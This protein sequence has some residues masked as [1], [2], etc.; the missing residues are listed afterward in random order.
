M[1]R[2]KANEANLEKR[3][4][5]W[6]F[7]GLV[8]ILAVTLSCVAWTSYDIRDIKNASLDLDLIEDEEIPINI[9]TPPPPPPPPQTTA[10]IE[11]VEDDEEIEEEP[12]VI[13][14][15]FDETEEIEIIEYEED[16]VE[17][18]EIFMIVEKMPAFPGCE[19]MRGDELKAC[20]ELEVR[21]FISG[22]TKYPQIAKDAGISGTVYVYY[23]INKQGKVENA[24]V[25]RGV[26]KS[27][28]S[29]ALRV[30]QSIPKHK[31]GEQRGKPVRVR[32]TVPV[33]FI[34]K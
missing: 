23:E 11:V 12:E 17:E 18:D 29:E 6:F 9:Q 15:E 2:I 1:D 4:S 25:L 26:H 30:I 27:L 19:G 7:M 33:K 13:I 5:G 10:V 28:D 22:N 32:Y 8:A 34:L 20:T 24:E 21:K 3:R 14:E 16:E 31:P